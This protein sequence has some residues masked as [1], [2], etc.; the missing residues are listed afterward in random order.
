[1]AQK[2]QIEL[3]P[4]STEN[5]IIFDIKGTSEEGLHKSIINGIRRTLL[6]TIPSIAFRTQIDDS[7]IIIN[8]NTTSLHNEFLIHRI[9]LIPLYIDPSKYKKQYLF[10]LD[11]ENTSEP[12]KTI[13]ADDFKIYRLKKDIDS[14]L[15]EDIKL[16]NY[17]MK[18]TIPNSEKKEILRPYNFKGQ[19]KYCIITELKNTN[20]SIYQKLNLYGV[21]S[22]SFGKENGRWQAV[23][24][25]TYS[26][27]KNNDLFQKILKD[28]MIV[29]NIDPDKSDEFEKD[30]SIKESE[31]YFYRDKDGE[32]FWYTFKIESVHF[33]NSKQLFIQANELI[34]DQLELIIKELPKLSS[35]DDSFI[36]ISSVKEDI[37]YKLIFQGY[38]D[39]IG[40]IIQSHIAMKMISEESVLATCGYK[41]K[42][43]LEEIIHFHVSLNQKNKIFKSN[44]QQKI[45]AIIQTF[46]EACGDLIQ[47]YSSIK[48]EATDNL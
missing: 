31:R 4:D 20:S 28:K 18:N 23:S 33:N 6:S 26:F 24:C 46:Q 32:P 29:E 8:E 34:I 25:A 39:T 42:H 3:S 41:K 13:T 9:S 44:N 5:D 17:N 40:N 22:I 37:I 15:I 16:D 30:L 2:I 47:I 38:D 43:P 7:D 1:M 21:P 12:I 27:K 10:H 36:S 11:V 45:I 19:D 48:K 14:N 35:E